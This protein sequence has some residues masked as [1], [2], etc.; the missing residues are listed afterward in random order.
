MTETDCRIDVAIR[1]R[2]LRRITMT[3]ALRLSQLSR[4]EFESERERRGAP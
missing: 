4:L 2:E 3:E 1:L